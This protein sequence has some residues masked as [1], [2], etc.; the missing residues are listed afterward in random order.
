MPYLSPPQAGFGMAGG[1]GNVYGET[2]RSRTSSWAKEATPPSQR[3]P[4]A[5]ISLH[6]D[7]GSCFNTWQLTDLVH[8]ALRL[9]RCLLVSGSRTAMGSP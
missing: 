7:L 9:P 2:M 1:C 3:R 4:L 6:P 8:V 5:S